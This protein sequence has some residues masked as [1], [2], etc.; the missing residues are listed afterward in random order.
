MIF[1]TDLFWKLKHRRRALRESMIVKYRGGSHTKSLFIK[2]QCHSRERS[3]TCTMKCTVFS[4]LLLVLITGLDCSPD[5]GFFISAPRVF[6]VGV[7]EKV[8]VQMGKS[9]L[10][11][12]V[13]VYLELEI[14]NVIM[15]AKKTTVCSVEGRTTTVE[16]MIDREMISRYP[17]TKYLMLVAESP[18]IQGR[19]LTR[20]LVSYRKGSI[21]IQ[22]DQPVYNPT[23]NVQYRIFTLDH[24]F[25]PTEE[26][27]QISII[28]AAGNTV[29][30]S[31]RSSTRGIYKN[32]FSIPDVSKM[33]TWKIKAHYLGDMA[34]VASREFKVQKFVLPSF[35]VNIETQQR[36]ILMDS[37]YF[38][39]T[40]LAKYSYGENVK[41]GYHCQFG[42]VDKDTT[43]G[44]K[45]RVTFIKGLEL[46]GSVQDGVAEASLQLEHLKE[47]LR[48]QIK[49]TISQI[50]QAKSQ[51]YMAVFVTNIQSGE[52]QDAEMYLPIVA[53][54]YSIDLSRTR[55]HFVPGFPLT[56]KAVVRHPNGS[57]AVG[58][59]VEINVP[60]SEPWSGPT[61]QQG[62]VFPVFNFSPVERITVTV[63]ADGVQ[64]TTDIKRTSSPSNSYLYLGIS[65]AIHSVGNSL[66][67]DFNTK[68]APAQGFI[69]YMVW[70]RG[71]LIKEGSVQLATVSK[72]NVPITSDMVPSFRLIGYYYDRNGNIVADSVWVDVR[73]ECEIN[74]KV[75]ATGSFRPARTSVLEFDLHGQS[76]RVALLAVDKAIYALHVDNK[77]TGKQVFKSMLSYD[78]GCTYG[79]GYTAETLLE[80]AGLSVVAPS[81]SGLLRRACD[82]VRHRR[83]VDLQQELITLKA[84]LTEKLQECCVNGFSHIPMGWT[85]D[86]RVKRV[87]LVEKN[88]KCIDI[89]S[90]CCKE[91]ERLRRKKAQEDAG[92][93]FGRTST[94]E[95]IEEFFLDTTAQEIRRYFPPSFDF[96][97]FDI[98]DKGRH[99]MPLPDSI[100]TWEIQAITL[101]PATGLCVVD[102]LEIRAF[103]PVF[104][105]LRLPYSVRKY[106][107]LSISPVIY[108]YGDET[109]MVAVHM[110]QHAKLC[111]PG[112]AT[113]TAF[114]NITVEPQ[115]SQFV[116]FSAVPMETGL[117]PIKIRI[118]DIGEGR[119]IDAIEKTLN[120]LTEG[121]EKSTEE[122]KSLN[123]DGRSSK[124]F[125]IDGSLPD[126]RVPGSG[127]SIFVS[128]EEDG[129]GITQVKNLLSPEKVAQLIRLPTGCVEQTMTKLAPTASAIRYLDLSDQWQ[130]LP[131]GARDKA[132]NDLDY[133][134]MR[135]IT[136]KKPNGSYPP[137]SSV[138]PSNWLTA[139][140]VKVL[141]LVAERQK[142]VV[143]QQ[144]RRGRTVPEDEIRHSV[145][146]LLTAQDT[147][148]SFLETQRV[149]HRGTLEGLDQKASMT[150]FVTLALHR[151][152]QFLQ[153]N[154]KND[155]EASIS[156]S[157]SYLQ[158]HFEELKNPYAVALS[159]YCFAVCLPKATDHSSA[160]AALEAKAVEGENNCFLWTTDPSPQNKRANAI[161]VETTAYALL[162]AVELGKTAWADKI[163]CWLTTQ[164]NYLGGYH[165][166]HDT[167]MTLEALAEYE[168]KRP[169]SSE[170]NLIAEFTAPRRTDVLKLVMNKKTDKVETDLTKFAGNN[171]LVQLS[172]K[173]EI[174][175]KVLKTYHLLEPKD[176][177]DKVAINVTVEGQVEYTAKI[178]ENYDYYEAYE[179]T[180]ADDDDT[181]TRV[182]R[183]AIE[184][185]DART[186]SRRD[187][188]NNINSD[189]TVT[190]KVCVSHSS[191]RKL[192]GMAIADITL[193]SGFEAVTQDLDKLKAEPERYISHYEISFGRVLMYF[194]DLV[195]SSECIMFR[196]TQKVPISLLQPAPALFYDY[197][198]PS[199]KC[200]VFYSAPKRSKM[201]SKLCSEDVCQCAE[202][203]CHKVQNAFQKNPEITKTTR[204][205]H[206]CFFPTVDYAY[207]VEVRS[208]STKSNFELYTTEVKEVFRSYEDN[209]SEDSERVFAKRLQC[210]VQLEVGQQYLIMG[211]DGSTTDPNG[212]MQ[213]LLES[214]TWIERKPQP[215]ECKKSANRKACRHFNK[216]IDEYKING[217]TQ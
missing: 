11:V 82:S 199:V 35:E 88:Q 168:L 5:T 143:G 113:A 41:G 45:E 146:F 145:R 148:G 20:V 30:K 194:N 90:T 120:V 1:R 115:T 149:L 191:E 114:V 19:Q 108:N 52:I 77:L 214:S 63:T 74:V 186:R 38:N 183:S 80:D 173:G 189:E 17:K 33:G 93:Q 109:I 86:D 92:K 2:T 212:R 72:A 147:D 196:A 128:A 179:D 139:L 36:F 160:W 97:E 32:G 89:F 13:T 25:R 4:V 81:T 132:L 79:G 107:Q 58:V 9:H 171:I 144:T 205:Q 106:E 95:E 126:D 111:S 22:T 207:I 91:G 40:I 59:P 137:Y 130:N 62:G 158:S 14:G 27:F 195:T 50:Q 44:Q 112:S 121:L 216:F 157:I 94:I 87:S 131:A 51:L 164:E 129:L 188:D 140:V 98:N 56:V 12:P 156:R 8:Y 176:A 67:V 101:S 125:T 78:S 76:A 7:A 209:V 192:S 65:D 155:A 211:K 99:S 57:P 96:K 100:T 66:S 215:E 37:Q 31:Y 200:T 61:D 172:G 83:S 197:Y 166:S 23:Q 24:R 190:Y 213:Y 117:I 177:C 60:S 150:A 208:I 39:F 202:K 203:P 46:T 68:N 161:T 71:N 102:P 178:L 16:L 170:T 29:M 124:T 10:N 42:V 169:A 64:Q 127:S 53:Q 138:T 136:F 122:T 55:S 69:Y 142:A 135:I 123:L 165:S 70:S 210:K 15:S 163:A 21:F 118:F 104:V 84:N 151:S 6:H 47:Q 134:Y 141:S 153:E 193:L 49:K 217:C 181:E 185:F 43:P 18:S 85:C 103:K 75:T 152:L 187:T 162:T 198:E 26:S 182:P 105:S 175:L 184:W 116:S 73:D 54:K 48:E 159:V 167:I 34:N 28:N 133:G 206:A 119:G 154:E 180:A 110:E 204:F 3:T 174:K 201:V